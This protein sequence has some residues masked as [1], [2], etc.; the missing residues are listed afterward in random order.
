MDKTRCKIEL[1]NNRFV[2]ATEWNDEIRIDVRE[3]ELKD[4][5]LIPTKKGISLSTAQMEATGGQFRVFGPGPNGE[6]GVPISSWGKCLRIRADQKRLLGPSSTLATPNNTEIV[7]TKKGICLRPAEY[8]K[9]KDVASV[10]GDFVPELCSIVPCP[11]SSDHQNQLGF[12][13]CSECNPD[14]FTE[15]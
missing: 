2:Q 6:E 12:F 10:I 4:E 13:R 9:L 5:K 3:W 15:W 8:V 14:H 7:P 1:G 11:Y